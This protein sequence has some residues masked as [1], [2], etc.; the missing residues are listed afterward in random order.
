MQGEASSGK[1]IWYT[2][3]S[4]SCITIPYFAS[5]QNVEKIILAC[6][7]LHNF[8]RE[9][10]T[11]TYSPP[12]SFDTKCTEDGTIN[13]GEWRQEGNENG[14][15]VKIR[16][17]TQKRQG[18]IF[19]HILI[20]LDVYPGKKSFFKSYVQQGKNYYFLDIVFLGLIV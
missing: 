14:R 13:E 4:F 11:G 2:G 7:V 3:E 12:G 19:V 10:S 17:L 8:L 5:T 16:L 20:R 15:E 1:R 9:K 18:K 6:C